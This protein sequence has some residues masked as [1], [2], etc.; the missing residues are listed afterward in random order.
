M[1]KNIVSQRLQIGPEARPLP[2]CAKSWHDYNKLSVLMSVV[3]C[4][5]NNTFKKRKDE[6]A[7]YYVDTGGHTGA[8]ELVV[9]STEG[10]EAKDE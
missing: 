5:V 10:E 2:P 6:H 8:K 9:L 4:Q 3:C 7:V 1:S